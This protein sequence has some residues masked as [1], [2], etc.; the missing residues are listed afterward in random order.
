MKRLHLLFGLVVIAAVLLLPSAPAGL[1]AGAPPIGLTAV[2]DQTL[3]LYPGTI[4]TKATTVPL[5]VDPANAAIAIRTS[6]TDKAKVV[7]NGDNLVITPEKAGTMYVE[8]TAA[9]AGYSSSS[10]TFAVH[11]VV[12]T[13]NGY[14]WDGSANIGGSGYVTGEIF[15]EI[16]SNVLY[17]MTDI[18]G[19]YRYDFSR[20]YWVGLNDEATDHS[21]AYNPTD[22]KGPGRGETFVTSIVPDPVKPGRVYM[23]AGGS[24]TNAAIYRSEDY[25]D[26]WQRFPTPSI[27]MNGNDQSNRSTGQRLAIDPKN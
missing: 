2:P 13:E 4:P 5:T 7:I 9:E 3:E 25:G 12:K 16:E 23:A 26:H 14:N 20:D 11:V 15:S 22:S 10:Q 24:A 17:A 1:G 6:S 8:V 18:G 19:A 27:S 21:S